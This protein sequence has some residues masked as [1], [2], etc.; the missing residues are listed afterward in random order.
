MAESEFQFVRG[1]LIDNLSILEYHKRTVDMIRNIDEQIEKL[2]GEAKAPE[3]R[4]F[5]NP[6]QEAI[7]LH[8]VKT[9]SVLMRQRERLKQK[10]VEIQE[11]LQEDMDA[12]K[13]VTPLK[14]LK[15]I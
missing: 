14:P 15:K 3:A 1:P 9:L 2:S 8:D 5:Q 12:S 13:S 11:R 4:Q 10:L 7:Y 6:R